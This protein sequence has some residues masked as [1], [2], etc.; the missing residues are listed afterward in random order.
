MNPILQQIQHHAAALEQK[1]REK[2]PITSNQVRCEGLAQALAQAVALNPFAEIAD[3]VVWQREQR[4][5]RN[6]FGRD[7]AD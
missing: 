2:T 4:Q 7:D 3:P 1:A 6:L 5:D